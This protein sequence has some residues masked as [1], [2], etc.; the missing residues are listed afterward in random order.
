MRPVL[1]E[2]ALHSGPDGAAQMGG[3]TDN[4]LRVNVDA[5]PEM[6]NRIVNV[7]LESLNPDTLEFQGFIV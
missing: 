7:R 5:C 2:H 1:L 4:Y 6:D 3:F